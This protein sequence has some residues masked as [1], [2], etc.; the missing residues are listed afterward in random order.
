[1]ENLPNIFFDADN[2]Q[3]LFPLCVLPDHCIFLSSGNIVVYSIFLIQAP[4]NVVFF[5]QVETLLF[6]INKN[7]Y[8]KISEC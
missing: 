4:E 3:H 5:F 1:M 6:T 2:R 7:P 8:E